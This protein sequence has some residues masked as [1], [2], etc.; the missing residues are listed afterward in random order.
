TFSF[1]SKGR[2][3]LHSMH[4]S[5]GLWVFPF[6]ILAV[7]SG[8]YWSYDWYRQGLHTISNVPMMTKQ[9]PMQTPKNSINTEN[10]QRTNQEQKKTNPANKVS[11]TDL[12]KAFNMFEIF[13]QKE[14]SNAMIRIP[15]S[16][17][18]YTIS[19]QD[20]DAAHS[21]ARNQMQIDINSWELLKSERYEDKPLN[22]QL[23]ASILPLHSGEYFGRIGQIIMFMTSMLMPLFAITGLMLYLNRTKKKKK[24]IK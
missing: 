15:T 12:S 3:L 21:R 1:K 5:I 10:Q 7:L 2:Y 13:L 22:Q 18:I 16:G 19:Y 11:Y 20:T 6:Y 24:A 4:S 9:M 14:Y 8:L 17:T 23:M